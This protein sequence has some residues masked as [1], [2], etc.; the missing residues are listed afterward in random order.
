VKKKTYGQQLL[1]HAQ[2]NPGPEDDVR[3]YRK[4]IEREQIQPLLVQAIE[5]ALKED[6]FKN[7]NFYIALIIKIEKIGAAPR[8]FA[9]PRLSC[10]T[11]HW[12]M[13]AFKYHCITMQLEFLYA[14]PD[15]EL[16][17]SI[18]LNKQ[19]YLNNAHL[20]DMVKFV[21]LFD[22]G[23]LLKWVKKENKESDGPMPIIQ[24]KETEC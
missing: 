17:K 5:T 24:Y 11:P 13:S 8:F 18:L 19:E 4:L 9:V 20:G 12:R 23:E 10:P 15:E 6:C 22:S 2:N 7:R 21:C 16:G 3:E 14:L 1:D